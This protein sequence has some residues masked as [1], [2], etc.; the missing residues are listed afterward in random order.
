MKTRIEVMTDSSIDDAL[1]ND[2]YKKKGRYYAKDGENYKIAWV[3]RNNWNQ[4]TYIDM[5]LLVNL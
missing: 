3:H 1:F 4:I 5:L 2:G